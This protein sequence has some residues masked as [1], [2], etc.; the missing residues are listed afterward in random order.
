MNVCSPISTPHLRQGA[1]TLVELLVSM[2]VLMLIMT[3][4]GQLLNTAQVITDGGN[5]H[6][7]SD[8]Q[9]SAVFDR[10]AID[11]AQMVKRPDVDYFLKDSTNTQTGNDQLAFYSQVPGYYLAAP[12]SH[13]SPVSLI[14]YRV[15]TGG[16]SANRLQRFGCGLS[17]NSTTPS[18]RPVVFSAASS[19]TAPNTISIN[20]PAATNMDEDSNYELAGPQVFR[21]EYGYLLKGQTSPNGTT[22]PSAPSTVPWDTRVGHAAVDG[23]RDVAAIVMTIAVIDSKSRVLVPDDKLTA[24]ISKMNDFSDSLKPGDLETQWQKAIDE[25]DIPRSAASAIRVYRRY[26]YLPSGSLLNL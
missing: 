24:L 7:D 26:F 20:W 12:A 22:L 18:A 4:I 21:M 16:P 6:L 9:A 11:F 19:S 15:N 17:W 3:L 5:K 25:S 14:A 2:T 23:M 10:I 8:A 1:F 13:Q